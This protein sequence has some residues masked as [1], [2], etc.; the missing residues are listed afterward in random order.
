VIK[1]DGGFV[2]MKNGEEIA[3][4]VEKRQLIFERFKDIIY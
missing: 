3:A 4:S 2:L 1:R